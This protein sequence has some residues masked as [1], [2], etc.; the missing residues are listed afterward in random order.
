MKFFLKVMVCFF[1]LLNSLAYAEN[2]DVYTFEEM[3]NITDGSVFGYKEISRS[4]FDL[5]LEMSSVE[6]AEWNNATSAEEIPNT[7]HAFKIT[8]TYGVEYQYFTT[9]GSLQYWGRDLFYLDSGSD[10][11]LDYGE[12]FQYGASITSMPAY[13]ARAETF[14]ESKNLI[15][16]DYVE[17]TEE[18]VSYATE[19]SILRPNMSWSTAIG[20]ITGSYYIMGSE[21]NGSVTKMFE[22][23]FH[24]KFAW[25]TYTSGFS[26]GGHVSI[27]EKH[28]LGAYI[29]G[30]AYPQNGASGLVDM[31]E[32]EV[33][34]TVPTGIYASI[35]GD[36]NVDV[37]FV[38]Q[39][40]EGR[41]QSLTGY[42]T[43][44]DGVKPYAGNISLEQ[45]M[46]Q[47]PFNL[48]VGSV[49]FDE[50]W[51]DG[52]KT[53]YMAVCEPEGLLT[54]K[55]YSLDSVQFELVTASAEN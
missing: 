20:D 29:D 5:G 4:T 21:T 41:V 30:V 55:I 22:T 51:S 11:T 46:P 27:K 39:D 26:S 33:E 43:L 24:P 48:K 32:I 17:D 19:F 9:I 18:I 12:R 10:L 49:L 54:G 28:L 13:I 8:R 16:T 15:E 23:R 31:D 3:F 40:R 7:A 52:I 35:F 25:L 42:N 38:F 14:T 53:L 45:L 37:Y 44:E 1:L 34:R 6:I 2:S 50:T 36:Q 47:H